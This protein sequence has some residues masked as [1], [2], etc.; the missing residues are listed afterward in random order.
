MAPENSLLRCSSGLGKYLLCIVFK[1]MLKYCFSNFLNI[2][3][4]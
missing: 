3:Y 4:K 2:G 1:D